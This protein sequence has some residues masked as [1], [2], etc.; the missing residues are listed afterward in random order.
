MSSRYS[1]SAGTGAPSGAA[2]GPDG[3]GALNV[4][5][6][7]HRSCQRASISAASAAEY[8]YG[9]G[10]SS[11]GGAGADSDSEFTVLDSSV[12]GSMVLDP[13]GLDPTVFI[14]RFLPCLP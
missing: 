8:R 12:P 10:V 4:P 9:G 11:L 14:L 6:A 7:S 2:S 5:S 3:F 13:T 1:L